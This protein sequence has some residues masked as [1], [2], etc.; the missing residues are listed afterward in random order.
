MDQQSATA[1]FAL[2]MAEEEA[3]QYAL[4]ERDYAHALALDPGND[5]MRRRYLQLQRRVAESNA[6]GNAPGPENAATHA[7]SSALP[8]VSPDPTPGG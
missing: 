2:A 3:Y 4:A 8:P 1:V 5:N 6:R 7:D